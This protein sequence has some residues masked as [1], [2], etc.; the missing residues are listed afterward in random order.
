MEIQSWMIR[1]WPNVEW[2][3]PAV[4]D[5]WPTFDHVGTKVYDQ[6]DAQGRCYGSTV[7]IGSI[8]GQ[9]TGAAWEWTEF[10]RGV[11]VMTDPN[12]IISN[13]QIRSPMGLFDSVGLNHI[14][15]SL[16]WQDMVCRIIRAM[17]DHPVPDAPPASATNAPRRALMA[18]A[19][20][21]VATV[22]A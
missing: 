10:R 16:P 22:R 13:L 12:T 3:L 15:H 14:A 7:W 8:N 19:R 11:V 2:Y 4:P 9:A 17:R 20:R 6:P 21:P 18:S 5:A 1:S